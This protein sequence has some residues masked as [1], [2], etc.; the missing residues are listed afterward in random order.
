MKPFIFEKTNKEGE[1]I[2]RFVDLDSVVYVE[3][4]KVTQDNPEGGEPVKIHFVDLHL[5]VTHDM[6]F[7]KKQSIKGTPQEFTYA[8]VP[9]TLKVTGEETIEKL[10]ELL[11][12]K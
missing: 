5:N 12:G 10:F 1:V 3:E 4:T 7:V 11:N 8:K 9:M 6:Q 2:R